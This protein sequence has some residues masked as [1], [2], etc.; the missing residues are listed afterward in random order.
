LL[1]LL[2][3]LKSL[4]AVKENGG[5]LS[6]EQ[7]LAKAIQELSDL[8]QKMHQSQGGPNAALSAEAEKH[9]QQ[10]MNEIRQLEDDMRLVSAMAGMLDLS[11]FQNNVHSPCRR[12]TDNIGRRS[13]FAH[14]R[15][16]RAR[17]NVSSRDDGARTH[18]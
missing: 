11:I 14:R 10:R 7:K 3:S 18:A 16:R 17:A 9:L 15:Q 12:V 1:N 8:R 4:D 6:T 13:R 2:E 5:H